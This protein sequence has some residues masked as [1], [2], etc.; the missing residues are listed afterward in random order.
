[1]SKNWNLHAIT[2][3][4]TEE[5]LRMCDDLLKDDPDPECQPKAP[6]TVPDNKPIRCYGAS[7]PRVT[8]I[9]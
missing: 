6:L 8:K 5:L 9:I 7:A 3:R 2:C 4:D 1:V